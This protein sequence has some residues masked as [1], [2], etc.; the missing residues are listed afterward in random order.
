MNPLTPALFASVVGASAIGGLAV[1]EAAAEP[2]AEQLIVFVQPGA[3]LLAERFSDETLPELE[4]LAE[5]SGAELTVIDI[6]QS[7]E[8]KRVPGGV[9]ITP[10]IAFQNHLGRSIYQGRYETLDR[11]RNFIRTS[12]F[13]PQGDEPLVRKELPVWNLGSAKVATPIKITDLVLEDGASGDG[14]DVSAE[15]LADA[16][17]G[18]DPRFNWADRV[19]LGRSDRLFYTDYYPYLAA[20]GTLYV[21]LALFSQFHCHDPVFT[22]T[23]G[24]LNGPATDA[25]EVFARGAKIFAD[26][27]AR[28]LKESDLGD[29]FDV[30]PEVTKTVSWEDVGLPLPPK[31]E[32]ASAEALANVELVQEWTIDE[33]AQ[34]FRPAVQFKFPAPLDAYS[35]EASSVFGTLTLGEGLSLEGSRGRFAADPASVTMG[36][37]ELDSAIHATMLEVESFPESYF[38]LERVETEFAQPAFG[39]VAAAVLHGSFTMK[40]VSIPLSVP[41]SVEAFLGDDGKPRLSIDGRWEVRLLD[42]FGIDGPPGDA[43]ANDTLIYTCHLVFEPA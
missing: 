37:S 16:I 32:G 10:L 41:A 31:P 19:E 28:Q 43:P 9:G 24:S 6:G 42:P 22:L 30:L 23:D 15:A 38:E 35:G 5:S 21:G 7:A 27:I 3:S 20:D 33:A 39:T 2:P 1:N 25:D 12:R 13:L 40:G 11:V 17:G 8:G 34:A 29:G 26:E 4:A 36:E 14:I 18:A